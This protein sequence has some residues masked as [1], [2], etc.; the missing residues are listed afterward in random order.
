M[1]KRKEMELTSGQA[2]IIAFYLP[3]YHSTPHNDEWWG[4]GFTEWT[5]VKKARPLFKGH[6]QPKIPS[7]LGYYDLSSPEIRQLQADLAREAGIEGFCYYHYWFGNGHEELDM[8]FKEV[9][10]LSKP[11]YPFCL[12][13]ANETWHKKF[14]NI[15]GAIEKKPLAVQTYEDAEGNKSHFYSLLSAFK[16]KRYIRVNGK[17]LFA[18]YKPLEFERLREFMNQ[19]NSL[20]QK[21]G[22][23][24][25]YFVGQ[26]Y[27]SPDIDK[28][29]SLGMDAC[30]IIHLWD[31]FPKYG[32]IMRKIVNSWR[33]ITKKPNIM[34]YN[35]VI[36]H[37]VTD[38]ER[39]RKIIPTIIPN[40]DHTPRSG[41][42]GGT[43]IYGS[44][45]QLFKK[46]VCQVLDVIKNKPEEE[47][48]V[49]LKSWNEWGEGNYMEPDKKWGKGY[50]HA[51]HEAINE[52]L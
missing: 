35:R 36:S 20:A 8:P 29:L 41:W 50:L 37:L 47:R 30:N 11:N 49:F 24:G 38:R 48:L 7:E 4:K 18:I 44:T 6:E 33:K 27:D 51:L 45:P 22:L 23:N 26:T 13:W 19:W 9:V 1:D 31:C 10:R 28:I 39:D 2:R 46:H 34:P 14:W 25:F 21:E 52:N 32:F 42:Q 5:N 17:L 15:D 43:V 40:W 16:D 3:Q 12:C